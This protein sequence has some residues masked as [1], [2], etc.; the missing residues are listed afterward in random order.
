MKAHRNARCWRFKGPP[1][2]EPCMACLV[3]DNAA[4]RGAV[5]VDGRAGLRRAVL[6]ARSPQGGV[7]DRSRLLICRCGPSCPPLLPC[8][9]RRPPGVP[10]WADP[11]E[12]STGPPRSSP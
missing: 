9:G 10:L 6:G 1:G 4:V 7:K 5:G 12:E 3:L 8:S 11:G 2:W